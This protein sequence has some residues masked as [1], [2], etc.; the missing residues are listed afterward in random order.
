MKL[1]RIITYAT[2][3][4]IPHTGY[5]PHTRP[6]WNKEVE[7][8]HTTERKLRRIW[9]SRGRPRGMHSESYRNYKRAKMHFRKA[10]QIP[11]ENYMRNVYK[12]LDEAAECDIRMFWKLV[13]RQKVKT[14]RTYPEIISSDG[15]SHRDPIGVAQAFA[16]YFQNIYTPSENSLFDRA[17]YL[18]T[19]AKYLN[20]KAQ[21]QHSRN[22]LPGGP[23]STNDISNIFVVKHPVQT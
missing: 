2:K 13:K 17:F 21:C 15:V 18:E 10:L 14:W 3:H 4:Y 8:L 9:I 11:Y 16:T 23:I 5:N 22:N 1:C 7:E 6:G 12:D 20:I 19:E